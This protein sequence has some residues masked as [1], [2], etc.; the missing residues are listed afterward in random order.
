MASKSLGALTI[1]LLLKMGG[2][3][4]GMD[5]AART[6]RST[7][8]KIERE[9][10]RAA[11]ATAAFAIAGV[12][13]GSALI[14]SSID[15][16][17]AMSKQSKIVGY[18]IDD[19]SGLAYA[20]ELSDVSFEQLTAGLTKSARAIQEAMEGTGAGADAFKALGIDV[21]D[22]NGQLRSNYDILGDVADRFAG[23]EDGALKTAYAQDLL[24]RSGAKLIPLLNGGRQGLAEMRSEAERLGQVF[25][26]DTGDAAEAFNDNLTRMRKVISGTGNQLAQDL[27]PQM[28]E[29]TDLIN[30]PETQESIRLV[31]KGI[32]DIAIGAAAAARELVQFSKWLGEA[33]AAAK[34]GPAWDDIPRLLEQ[35]ESLEQ[36]RTRIR[37]ANATEQRQQLDDQIAALRTQIDLV[38]SLRAPVVP[39]PVADP[40]APTA[41]GGSGVDVETGLST[42]LATRIASYQEQ[43]ALV[44]EIT[45]LER[46][47][48]D[49][50]SG[51]LRGLEEA[52]QLR[53]ESLAEE[54][55]GI[56][57][58]DEAIKTAAELRK[59]T[60][61]DEQTRLA[62]LQDQYQG[63]AELIALGPEGGGVSQEEGSS[64]AA[65][66][67]S[68]YE[69]ADPLLQ[70]FE[71]LEESMFRQVAT[72]NLLTETERVGFEIAF[73]NLTLLDEAQ[74]ARIMLLAEELDALDA[75]AEADKARTEQIKEQMEVIEEIGKEAA[76]SMQSTFSDF[77]FD[78]FDGGLKGMAKSFGQ[79][80]RKMSADALSSSV[81]KSVFGGLAKSANPY[82][83]AFG[84]MFDSGGTLNAGEW[85]IVGE[86]G[87]E[88]VRGPAVITGRAETARMM[89]GAGSGGGVNLNIINNAPV[90]VTPGPRRMEG[91]RIQQDIII[92]QLRSAVQDGAI[93]DVM[94]SAY[95]V[96]RARGIG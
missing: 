5:K 49:I 22:A 63:L 77:L 55:D 71:A 58:K 35:I 44:G 65:A 33:F 78:P 39:V 93:D 12:V 11:K 30:E 80:L 4:V 26:Q 37:G 16:A 72:R 10:N 14:K 24:G 48:Y 68:A 28:V 43:I 7:S 83:A 47:R 95:G 6:A 29:F 19:L 42:A 66:L 2:F 17:D 18:A 1:D 91:G 27:L 75:A 92:E 20:A 32:A 84:G 51:E 52:D 34:H 36:R 69:A 87:P 59:S 90:T 53:L 8:G 61:T 57:A 23:M 21:M 40:S 70:Q 85:G 89:G 82:L 76:R 31:V 56:K 64:I 50:N 86:V 60:M 41:E 79:T 54:L 67:A 46:L 13:A 38:N 94:G 45:E 74:Q 15:T 3:E 73:G 9:M 96:T 88:I 62:T 25:D 81:L